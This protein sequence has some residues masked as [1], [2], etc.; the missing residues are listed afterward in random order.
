MEDG[1]HVKSCMCCVYLG[2]VGKIN[3]KI[4]IIL[5]VMLNVVTS[6]FLWWPHLV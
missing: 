1:G 5:G 6:D 4:G 3:H 2:C